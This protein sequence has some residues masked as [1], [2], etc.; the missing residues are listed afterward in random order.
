MYVYIAGEKAVVGKA[1]RGRK[2]RG[3]EICQKKNGRTFSISSV[4]L[5]LYTKLEKKPAKKYTTD[6]HKK[7]STNDNSRQCFFK[8]ELDNLN[9]L[10]S[11]F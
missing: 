9:T 1:T 8:V 6:H 10:I 3:F 2:K 11:S 4:G 7:L 5:S